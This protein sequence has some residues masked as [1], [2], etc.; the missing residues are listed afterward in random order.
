M[1]CKA[2]DLFLPVKSG[3]INLQYTGINYIATVDTA[4][5]VVNH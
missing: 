2:D 3:L 4:T 5:F 1:S